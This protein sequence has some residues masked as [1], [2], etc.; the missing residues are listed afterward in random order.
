MLRLIAREP[1]IAD[2]VSTR[3][4]TVKALTESSTLPAVV[5]PLSVAALIGGGLAEEHPE[6]YSSGSCQISTLGG[7]VLDLLE[8]WA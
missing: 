8:T 4:W 1:P 7:V 3:F 6:V 2:G 5:V